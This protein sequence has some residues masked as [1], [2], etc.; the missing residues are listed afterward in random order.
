MGK[1]P[2]KGCEY[3]HSLFAIPVTVKLLDLST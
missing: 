1:K 2:M 3:K